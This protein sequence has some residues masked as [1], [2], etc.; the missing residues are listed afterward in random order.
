MRFTA[1][2]ANSD[3]VTPLILTHFSLEAVT[4]L[5]VGP[6]RFRSKNPIRPHQ[7]SRVEKRAYATAH[8]SC[9]LIDAR[10]SAPGRSR[11]EYTKSESQSGTPKGGNCLLIEGHF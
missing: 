3:A 6:M 7:F 5:I 10:F 1:S 2:L 8:H 11:G 4:A 9:V